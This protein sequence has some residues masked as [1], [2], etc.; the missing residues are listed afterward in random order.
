MPVLAAI[1]QRKPCRAALDCG[2]VDF[3]GETAFA[4]Q[5]G[6]VEADALTKH[7]QLIFI[8]SISRKCQTGS[9]IRLDLG[10]AG[11]ARGAVDLTRGVARVRRCELNID[12]AEFSGLAGTTHWRLTAKVF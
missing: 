10:L 1:R 12:R 5:L 7:A 3:R 6:A 11:A 8:C 4:L 9:R 2:A